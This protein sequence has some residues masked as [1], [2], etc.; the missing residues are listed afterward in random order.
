MYSGSFY[1]IETSFPI[2]LKR[3]A[4]GALAQSRNLPLKRPRR[5]HEGLPEVYKSD[6][7]GGSLNISPEYFCGSGLL[8]LAVGI[9][10]F[11][12][13]K[14]KRR[15]ALKELMEQWL[16]TVLLTGFHA[17]L[18]NILSMVSYRKKKSF[19]RDHIGSDSGRK[20]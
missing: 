4:G 3:F 2:R 15:A 17:R 10:I 14:R 9:V 16:I 13:E 19:P 5:M 1:S 11:V 20:R 6:V 7:H 12:L 18:Q 8:L